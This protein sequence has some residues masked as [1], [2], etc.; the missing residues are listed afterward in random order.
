MTEEASAPRVFDSIPSEVERIGRM[1]IGCGI[2]VH[3]YLG[4]GYKEAIYVESMC[5]EM[6]SRGIKYEREKSILVF[7]RGKPVGSHRLDLLIEGV[8][9]LECKVAECLLK[10]HTRQVV[11]YLKATDLR[12]GYVFNFN[13]DVL[14]E[15]GI[16]RVVL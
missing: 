14:T 10:I 4:P 15:G 1:V 2:A 9:I 12:L 5:L 3:R 13:V 11:S 16:K 6:D 7:Y 8:L